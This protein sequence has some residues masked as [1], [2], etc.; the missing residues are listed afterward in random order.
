MNLRGNKTSVTCKIETAVDS[1][2]AWSIK[3]NAGLWWAMKESKITIAEI[4]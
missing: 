3:Q 1:R 4:L 2:V